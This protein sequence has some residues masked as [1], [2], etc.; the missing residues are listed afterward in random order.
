MYRDSQGRTR[1]EM[2]RVLP[3]GATFPTQLP[4]MIYITDPVAGVHYTLDVNK[5][6]A[7]RMVFPK[8]PPP[9][10]TGANGAI[11]TVTS[12]T[13]AGG[14]GACVIGYVDINGGPVVTSPYPDL[15]SSQA[16]VPTV[17]PQCK[18]ESLGAQV[19]EGLLC[20]GHRTVTTYPAGMYD[21]NRE[22]VA[23]TETWVSQELGFTILMRRSDPR[24]GD[25]IMRT[26]INRSEPDPALFMVP[27]DYTIEDQPVV[28]PK[29]QQ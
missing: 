2:I 7:H 21:N 12:R 23:T 16:N 13:A 15:A 6:I 1:I 3:P 18:S 22:L 20:D 11:G 19:V 10:T 14:I 27:P 24:T 17:R 26:E 29:P 28:G 8:M 5:K 9:G 4:R 25:N